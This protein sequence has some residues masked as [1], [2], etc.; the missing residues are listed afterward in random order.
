[1]IKRQLT[2]LCA[3]A[4]LSVGVTAVAH[5]PADTDFG[6]AP[7]AKL[8]P[9]TCD[10]LADKLNYSDDVS[11]PDI[12]ALKAGCDDKAKAEPAAAPKAESAKAD[13]AKPE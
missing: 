12:K 9:T 2:L 8:V 6:H 7:T 5:N 13:V 1:M 10:Q 3:I 11:N 4:G